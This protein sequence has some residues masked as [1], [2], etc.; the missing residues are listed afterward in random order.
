LQE[1]EEM[2]SRLWTVLTFAAFL[3][4]FTPE[5]GLAAPTDQ[6]AVRWSELHPVLKRRQISVQLTDGTAVEG[7][8]SNLQADAL[9]IQVRKTSD[10]AK[11]PKGAT[12]LARSELVEITVMRH[13]GWKG[14]TIGL[15]TGVAVGA[16]AAGT[17]H[18]ISKNE[19]GGWSSSS[20]STAAAGGGGAIG[21]G[22]L[23]GWLCDLVGS[24]PERVIRILPDT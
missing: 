4:S 2:T 18:A 7:R 14:R 3:F 8:Y 12:Q 23:I 9:S 17:L 1:E 13:R 22:Y 10:A 16:I 21:I 5:I 24:R 15:I 11:H 6:L 19:V 20:A